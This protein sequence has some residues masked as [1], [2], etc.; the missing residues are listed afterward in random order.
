MTFGDRIGNLRKE[1]GMSLEALAE[2]LEVPVEDLREWEQDKALPGYGDRLK[3]CGYFHVTT[4]YLEGREEES[5][6][7]HQGRFSKAEIIFILDGAL[8]LLCFLLAPVFQWAN[9]SLF[10]ECFSDPINY[11]REFP[12]NIL[13]YLACAILVVQVG[14]IIYEKTKGSK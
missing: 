9:S 13:F 6:P 3:L 10:G 1:K 12:L 11:L 5:R 8:F 4:A 2:A 14:K 7:V